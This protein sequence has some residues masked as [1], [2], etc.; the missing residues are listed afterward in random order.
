MFINSRMAT[1]EK[2]R[3]IPGKC[4]DIPWYSGI[5]RDIP[6]YSVIF[7]HIPWYSGILGFHNAPSTTV[8]TAKL[9]FSA[10]KTLP[11]LTRIYLYQSLSKLL[12]KHCY[13]CETIEI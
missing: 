10:T 12:Y 9:V 4:R 8:Q 11:D 3:D 13:N 2:Y 1:I 5:F 6:V 7:R